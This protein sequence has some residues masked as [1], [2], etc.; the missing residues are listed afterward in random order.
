MVSVPLY[1]TLGPES[2]E[3]I[4]N[5]AELSC[6]GCSAQ[7]L[8]VL[9][10]CLPRCPTVKVLVGRRTGGRGGVC[11]DAIGTT[12]PWLDG[13]P[14][15]I[16]SGRFVVALRIV[17]NEVAGRVNVA[18]C[19]PFQIVWGQTTG[20][21]PDPPMGSHVRIVSL[22]QV[23]SWVRGLSPFCWNMIMQSGR[24]LHH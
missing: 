19:I 22:D 24:E 4:C 16:L 5:H 1:D 6:V 7:V 10:E 18:P 23:S 15:A 11:L 20:R 14:V 2:V 17:C 9:L 21:L 13:Q 12:A 3:Y 8:P